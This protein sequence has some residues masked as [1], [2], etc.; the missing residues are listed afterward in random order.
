MSFS[1]MNAPAT[2]QSLINKVFESFIGKRVV[3]YLD[4]IFIYSKTKKEHYWILKQVLAL[5]EKNLLFAKLSKCKFLLEWI[6]FLG[7]VISGEG[8]ATDSK[9][10]TAIWE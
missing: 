5:L 6:E 7:H 10:S 4:N 9:K 3:V 8:I 1:F 2:F